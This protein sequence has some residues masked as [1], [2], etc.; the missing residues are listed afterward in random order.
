MFKNTLEW[1]PA[2][3]LAAT[4][5]INTPQSQPFSCWGH[6]ITSTSTHTHTYKVI[7]THTHTQAQTPA[8]FILD[9]FARPVHNARYARKV[10]HTHSHTYTCLPESSHCTPHSYWLTSLAPRK[11]TFIPASRQTPNNST[12]PIRTP[13]RR[14]I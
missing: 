6:S 12:H 3:K 2:H 13:R 10:T 8:T 5:K 7:H 11:T 1:R 4:A 14:K 9:R